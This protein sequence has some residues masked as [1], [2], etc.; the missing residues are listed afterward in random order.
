[1][2]HFIMD[3]QFTPCIGVPKTIPLTEAQTAEL[4]SKTLIFMK[5]KK[6]PASMLLGWAYPRI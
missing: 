2:L 1:M 5:K 6:V 3:I 4:L